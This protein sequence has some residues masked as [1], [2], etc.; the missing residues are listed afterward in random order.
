MVKL[1]QASALPAKK[2][3]YRMGGWA[4]GATCGMR[5]MGGET[6]GAGPT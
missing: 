3:G 2:T 6:V 1:R 4:S 5:C